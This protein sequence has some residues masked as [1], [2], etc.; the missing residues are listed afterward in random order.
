MLT[1]QQ[2]A[3]I[4]D[5][6]RANPKGIKTRHIVKELNFDV[7][8]KSEINRYFSDH[9][10]KYKKDSSGLN[11]LIEDVPLTTESVLQEQP[12]PKESNVVLAKCEEIVRQPVSVPNQQ[13]ISAADAAVL[14]A[15]LEKW[16][17]ETAHAKGKPPYMILKNLALDEISHARLARRSDLKKITGI[18]EVKY[19][20]YGNAIYKIYCD[21]HEINAGELPSSEKRIASPPVVIE[22]KTERVC[23]NCCNN[24]TD[25]CDKPIH[26]ESDAKTCASFKIKG[27]VS[28]DAYDARTAKIN[29][30]G[31]KAAPIPD[32]INKLGK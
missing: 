19:R 26:K 29:E 13:E 5:I 6:L 7:S 12:K 32:R 28:T 20:Q 11:Y 16:R 22:E 8:Y 2:I 31:K 23:S 1:K 3:Q 9:K 27:I 15:Q 17:T 4:D 30:L 10:K 25:R 21:Y 24:N 14:F 18:G